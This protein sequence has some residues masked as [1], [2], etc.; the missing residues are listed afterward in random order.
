MLGL[1]RFAP[2]SLTCLLMLVLAG[3]VKADVIENL[4]FEGFATCSNPSLNPCTIFP[5]GPVTGA[6]NWDVTT[7]AIVGAWS[8]SVPFGVLASSDAGASATTEPQNG[9]TRD[10]FI[11]EPL[12][13]LAFVSLTFPGMNTDEIGSVVVVS[14][15]CIPSGVGASCFPD[16]SITGATT[17]VNT[18]TTPEPAFVGLPALLGL[19]FILNHRRL[20]PQTSR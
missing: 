7:Q 12:N 11:V 19:I 9:N 2:I 8:F 18:V 14:D 1:K 10:D 3:S 5:S 15:A 17:L 13:S 20:G 4:S 16:Y 6:F